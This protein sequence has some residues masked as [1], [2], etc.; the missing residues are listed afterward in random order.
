MAQKVLAQQFLDNYRTLIEQ[1]YQ[2]QQ[3]GYTLV[4][5]ILLIYCFILF[6]YFIFLDKQKGTDVTIDEHFRKSL[7][8]NYDK[9]T[10]GFLTPEDSSL[11][12]SPT[13]RTPGSIRNKKNKLK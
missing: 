3:C 2:N 11:N 5:G 10:G 8:D 9:F 1:Q 12:S 6:K 4:E 13:E 7:G